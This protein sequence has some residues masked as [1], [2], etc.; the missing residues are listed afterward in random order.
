VRGLGAVPKL[1]PAAW[2]V[3]GLG[4]RGLDLSLTTLRERTV[5]ATLQCAGNRRT[6]LI[7]IRDIPGEAPWGPG[8]AGTATWTVVAPADVLRSPARRGPRNT[9]P[10]FDVRQHPDGR[11]RDRAV[12]T[13]RPE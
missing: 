3:H 4:E 5:T 12:Q 1:D 7:A 10:R 8:A 2:R 13:A 6:G 11:N 9:S